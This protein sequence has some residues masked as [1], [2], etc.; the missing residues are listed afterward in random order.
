MLIKKLKNDE[1][2]WNGDPVYD[3][4]ATKDMDS[5]SVYVRKIKIK[6]KDKAEQLT[7]Q[8]YDDFKHFIKRPLD[9][10]VIKR[11]L[12]RSIQRQKYDKAAFFGDKDDKKK[13]DW[14][15]DDEFH[16]PPKGK[17][18]NPRINFTR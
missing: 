17:E 10:K 8:Y 11:I 9:N 12:D 18:G 6:D 16:P 14:Q 1:E 4:N 15:S 2:K 3:P 13:Q 7:K 5:L